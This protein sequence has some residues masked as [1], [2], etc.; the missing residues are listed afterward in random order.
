VHVTRAPEQRAAA[1]AAVT[2]RAFMDEQ[3]LRWPLG[4][5]ADPAAALEREFLGTHRNAARHG[6]LWEAGDGDGVAVWIEP[7]ALAAFWDALMTWD[8][9]ATFAADG[10]ARHHAMWEWIAGRYPDRP[11]WFLDSVA[12]EPD[13]Q[14]GG[15]GSTLIRH[16]LE[17]ADGA[18]AFLETS[19]AEL[20]GYYQR[21][22]FAV[23]DEG[24]APGGGPHVWFMRAGG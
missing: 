24:D 23:F 14:G 4:E 13:R 20:V 8:G 5:V 3:L 7:P 6:C 1:L 9:A 17:R 22:G 11:A 21:F 18:E 10:G 19:R 15:I 2:T 16:G 12:V